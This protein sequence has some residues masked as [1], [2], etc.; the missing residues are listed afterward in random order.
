LGRKRR[1]SSVFF[2][3]GNCSCYVTQWTNEAC[4]ETTSCDRAVQAITIH[5]RPRRFSVSSLSIKHRL[6]LLIGTLL[7]GIIT[8]STWASY[9]GVK[10]SAVKAGR[11][12]LQNLTQQLASMSQQSTVLLLNRTFTAANDPA[13]RAFLQAPSPVTR[14]GASV[15]LQQFTAAQE[16]N[17]LQVELWD[18]NRSLVLTEPDGAS[19][20]PV[21]L[22]TDFTQCARDPF[23]AVGA[24]RIVRDIVV[25]PALAAV[26]DDSGKSI[27]YLVRWR[28]VS[29]TPEPRRLRDLLGSEASLYFGNIEGD[30]WTDLVKPVPKPPTDLASTLTVTHYMRDGNSM[31]ALGRPI[32][33]TPYFVIVEFPDRVVLSGVD[34]FLRRVVVIDSVLFAIGIV[35]ALA[36]SR[37]ITR[38][39]RSLT[40]AARAISAGDYSGVTDTSRNDELGALCSAFNVMVAKVGDSQRELEGKVHALRGSEQRLQTVIENLSDG[41]FISDMN[42]QLLNWNKAALEMHGCAN[43]EE[44]LFNLPEFA[45]IFELSEL[46]GAVLNVEQWP[47]ARIIRGEELNN[48]ELRL[49][50]IDSDWNRIFNYGGAIVLEAAGKSV[51]FVMITDITERKRA[52]EER[53]QSA[54]IVGSS[55]D[56]IVGKTLDGTIT[57]W[58][59]GAQKLYG[60]AAEEVVGRSIT[61]LAL[62]EHCDEVPAIL[63]RLRQGDIIDH[64]ETERVAKGGERISVSLTISP[65]RDE[66]GAISGWSSIARDITKRKHAEEALQTSEVRYRRLFES[67]K[68]GILILDADSGQIIDVNP[69]LSDLLGMSKEELAGKELWEIGPFKDIVASKIAFAELQRRGY[70]RYE[71]LPLES[72]DG[73]VRQ[74]EFV[75]NSYL[76]GENRVI[77]CNIRDI[78]ERKQA[79]AALRASEGRY[80]TLFEY[81]PDGIVIA[82]SESYYVDAN[83]TMCRMLG[84]TRDEL[85]GLH[86][87]DIVAQTEIPHIGSALSVINA[88]S[89]HHREWQFRRKEG[90]FF[91]AEVIATMM[92]DGNL[93]GM[94]RDITERKLVEEELL[95]TNQSLERALAELQTRTQELASM[96]QQLWQASKLATMGELAA[97]VAH[98]LNNPLATISLRAELLV[99]QL[100]AND[101]NLESLSVIEQE[102]ERMAAL[103]SNL[104]LFS[105]RSHQQ[106][107]T[108]DIAEELRNSLEFMNYH[109]RSHEITVTTDFTND[110]PTVQADTQQLRQVFLNLLTNASDAMPEGGTLTVR[111]RDQALETGKPAVL[112]EF[113]DSG[114][115]VEPE[116]LP[117]LWEPFFTTKPEG[118]GTGLGLPICRRTVEEHHGTIEIESLPGRGTTVR[119]ILPATEGGE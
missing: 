114:V 37:N 13:I 90:S 11:E 107:T 92:P 38:P 101:P 113:T 72:R 64:F 36:L 60:Y 32:G 16:P 117:K 89:D 19:P 51:A 59:Q 49:R 65:I 50:R 97:S 88:K 22:K 4:L 58:N 45:R 33:G 74:V 111:A 68:D 21:D 84:Y 48:V 47:L 75:S 15:I 98:E 39:L 70:I 7:L 23:R 80:H 73:L 42:G 112:I 109:L 29:A 31:M 69:Y 81:A 10:E 95:R 30:V 5:M 96:T 63:E 85:I 46:D 57:S 67:A 91:A 104:L 56:A 53:R 14:S 116:N 55:E 41:L 1:P 54:L 86:A 87:S 71:N 3:R 8:A 102:V 62:P 82:D 61:I 79:E 105:R 118:K 93:L 66:S 106:I 110:L 43:S 94:V 17:N 35:G 34:R 52:E 77:Q 28:R 12:R 20:E 78:T 99:S 9:R 83:A 26:K 100:A 6:P 27:G 24:L 108:V 44:C 18:T 103:V 119:I 76:A 115:G 40:K 2:K 25:S